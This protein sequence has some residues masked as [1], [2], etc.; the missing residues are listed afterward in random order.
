MNPRFIL[1]ETISNLSPNSI[2][3][4]K[5]IIQNLTPLEF[6]IRANDQKYYHKIKSILKVNTYNILKFSIDN[7]FIW[8]IIDNLNFKNLNNLDNSY[9]VKLL[10]NQK[11]NYKIKEIIINYIDNIDYKEVESL[12][13][14]IIRKI[15]KRKIYFS[16]SRKEIASLPDNK[17][18]SFIDF[19]SLTYINKNLKNDNFI[20]FLFE[21]K[22][23]LLDKYYSED[24]SNQLNRII[25][26]LDKEMIE[27]LSM[28]QF[29]LIFRKLNI[30]FI[31]KKY[32]DHI[33]NFFSY[34]VFKSN[35][36]SNAKKMVKIFEYNFY[37]SYPLIIQKNLFLLNS[38]YQIKLIDFICH[39]KTAKF[40]EEF[41]KHIKNK[42]LERHVKQLFREKNKENFKKS[43]LK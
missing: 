31:S 26:L 25:L 23:Y 21:E 12:P 34:R 13:E 22:I 40:I 8:G 14:I 17:L 10:K 6:A 24:L 19:F 43:L 33:I 30:K 39:N 35:N 27:N 18:S 20:E 4:N 38:D 3:W 11:I 7:D 41:K 1:S 5:K 29:F 16:Y 37:Y 9:K 2:L 15:P 42:N 36:L 28:D 32:Q